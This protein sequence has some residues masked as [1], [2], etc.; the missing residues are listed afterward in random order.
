MNTQV[1]VSHDTSLDYLQQ[2][3]NANA[4]IFQF[5]H[6]GI[7]NTTHVATGEVFSSRTPTRTRKKWLFTVEYDVERRESTHIQDMRGTFFFCWRHLW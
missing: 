2:K 4:E 6:R 3:L 1:K 7:Q 5:V